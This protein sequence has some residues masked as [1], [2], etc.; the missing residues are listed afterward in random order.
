MAAVMITLRADFNRM[1]AQG[2]LRSEDLRM[3][4]QTPF[5]E[6]AAKHEQII[7]VDGQDRVCDKTLHDPRLGWI[8]TVERSTQDVWQ[9]YVRWR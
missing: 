9:G 8:G 4:E 2:Q 5:A 6:I 1:D 7:F 3:H